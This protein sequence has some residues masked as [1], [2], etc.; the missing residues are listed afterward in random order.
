[1]MRMHVL[2]SGD[3]AHGTSSL[4]TLLY[5]SVQSLHDLATQPRAFSP[6]LYK[7]HR[8]LHLGQVY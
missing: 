8:D 7:S 4:Y 3:M 5:T 2:L 6:R 1:M